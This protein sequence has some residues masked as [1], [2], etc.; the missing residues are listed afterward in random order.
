MIIILIINY[1]YL[2][3]LLILIKCMHLNVFIYLNIFLIRE[4]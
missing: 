3:Y 1:K 4:Q 2:S